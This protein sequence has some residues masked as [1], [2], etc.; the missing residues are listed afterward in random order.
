MA[1][2]DDDQPKKK[3]NS[4]PLWGNTQTMNLNNL[5]VTN[6]LSSPY[7]KNDLIKL[8]TFHE[9]VDEIYYKVEHLEPWER[10]SR[11]THGQVGMCGGVRGVGA[12]GIASTSFC[13]LFKL[14]T[15]KLTEKQVFAL[16]NH[17]D[18]PY[19]RALGFMFVRY[20]QDPKKFWYW[21]EQYLEDEEEV[22][23][24]A[25]GG[26]MMTIGQMV[27]SFIL[28]LDWYGTLFPR[29]PVPVHKDLEK[30]L[31]DRNLCD[32]RK[33]KA[34]EVTDEP[35]Q[36]EPEARD[37]REEKSQ[38]GEAERYAKLKREED[39]RDRDSSHSRHS[40]S[41]RQD[42]RH[43][44][45]DRKR[46]RDREGHG[47]DRRDRDRDRGSRGKDHKRERDRE[48]KRS[49]SPRK[50]SRSPR[51]GSRSPRR[52]SR[53]PPRHSRS[54]VKSKDRHGHRSKSPKMRE[55]R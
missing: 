19:I 54:P 48:R 27:R 7:F 16:I 33:R 53:S 6:I 5:V 46:E 21:F 40:S 4:L 14:F 41:S 25:G 10:G 9:V 55:Y 39:R 32:D 26:S 3:G 18:S 1:D 30:K 52:R 34:N 17:P 38:F 50:R 45:R 20:C 23:P 49:R 28:K 11:K 42:D 36:P 47:H 29:I 13:L 12:G 35:K 44:D 31:K 2:G 24:K 15:L 43:K 37:K 8:K 22:D 51:R